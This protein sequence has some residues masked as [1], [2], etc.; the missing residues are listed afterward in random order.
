MKFFETSLPGCVVIEPEPVRDG[1]GQFAR[2]YCAEEFK[3]FGLNT[4]WAQSNLVQSVGVG[5]L[6]GLH[7]QRSPMQEVKLVRC[8]RGAVWDVV[9]DLRSESPTYSKWFGIELSA[10][11][12]KAIY[13][14]QGFAH[15][16]VTLQA[17]SDVMYMVSTMY[18]PDH[19]VGV[20]WDDP[21]IGIEWPISPKLISEKD[22]A[23]ASLVSLQ[24]R[25]AN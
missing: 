7:L 12:Q 17:E 10:T 5:V 11:S 6:R 14:P 18:S 16:Y 21:D 24:E 23:N 2:V 1:R 19:E 8:I 9:V 4:Q 20:A 22:Q 15:G 3:E 13:V 25:R